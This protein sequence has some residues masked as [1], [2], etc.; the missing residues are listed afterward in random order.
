V[1]AELLDRG[2]PVLVITGLN[3][4]K[5]TNFLG[6]RKWVSKMS[7]HGAARYRQAPSEQWKVGGSVLGYRRTGGGL[8]TLEVLNAGH[9]APR[10]Q[11]RIADALRQFIA[12]A[13]RRG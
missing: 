1:V 7:W 10:D 3:D 12:A 11:P 13:S 8:T 2:V 5:D 4:G 6:V 9:L